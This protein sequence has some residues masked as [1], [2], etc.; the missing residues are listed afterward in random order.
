[1]SEKMEDKALLAHE[2]DI[3]ER[4]LLDWLRAH[5]SWMK[6]LHRYEGELTLEEDRLI[7]EG[8]DTKEDRHYKKEIRKEDVTEVY[9]GFDDSFRRREDRSIGIRFKPLRVNYKE[10][11][12]ERTMYF[13][14]DFSRLTRGSNNKE[15][16]EALREW[17]EE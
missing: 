10:N 15:W 14:T 4:G 3:K 11:D 16:Y 17:I 1:M 12:K 6:P 5:T 13:V 2:E 8:E 9:H 7:F